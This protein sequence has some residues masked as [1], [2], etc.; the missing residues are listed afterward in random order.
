[1]DS[2]AGMPYLYNYFAL[3]G[4][5]YSNI[6]RFNDAVANFSEA[7]TLLPHP[8]Y[9]YHRGLALVA[10]GRMEEAKDDIRKAGVDTGPVKWL[11]Y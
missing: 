1:M 2:T 7:I 6:G 3:R 8:N 5:A 9:Y 4:S 10:M 11:E